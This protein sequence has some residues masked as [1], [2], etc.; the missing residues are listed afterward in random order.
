ME[1]S[2]FGTVG[3]L[4]FVTLLP[5]GGSPLKK[6]LNHF[7]QPVCGVMTRCLRLGTYAGDFPPS[8]PLFGPVGMLDVDLFQR[9][10]R[11][12][13]VAPDA[14][15]G[16]ERRLVLSSLMGGAIACHDAMLTT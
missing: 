11:A 4:R 13:E 3:L 2:A 14:C 12:F 15:I 10:Y 16:F 6:L 9:D 8:K 1:G 5:W 7:R